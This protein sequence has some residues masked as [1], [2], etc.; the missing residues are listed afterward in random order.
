MACG[1]AAVPSS[2]DV[3]TVGRGAPASGRPDNDPGGNSLRL[4]PSGPDRVGEAPVRHR[5]PS[6]CIDG[7]G[8][9]GQA[10]WVV[11]QFERHLPT[12]A[13]AAGS[14]GLNSRIPPVAGF[15]HRKRLSVRVTTLPQSAFNPRP[16]LPLAGGN[17]VI[18]LSIQDYCDPG[19][20]PRRGQRSGQS[21]AVGIT[22][23]TRGRLPQP[24]YF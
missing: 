17:D 10:G 12:Q 9:A 8:G 11:G 14:P 16:R 19:K 2:R 1:A 21:A 6:L 7:S 15:R 23:E 18:G 4:L 20:V 3:A 24:R 5:S 22:V 13:A